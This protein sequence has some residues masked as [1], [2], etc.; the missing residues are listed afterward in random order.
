MRWLFIATPLL[1]FSLMVGAADNVVNFYTWADYVPA[2]IIKQFEKETG[3]TVNVSEFSNNDVMYTKIKTNPRAGYDVVLLSSDYLQ[4]MAKEGML[5]Q[6]NPRHI[7]N[8]VHIDTKEFN[9]PTD[10]LNHL[11]VPFFW[12]TTGILVNDKYWDPATIQ[13]WSDLW[14][15]RFKDQVLLFDDSI[16]TFAVG[17]KALHYSLNSTSATEIHAAYEKLRKLMPNVRLFNTDAVINI[18]ID[19]DATIGMVWNGD[20]ALAHKENPHLQF[21]YPKDG[22]TIWVDYFAV[23]SQAQHLRNAERL[24]NFF[25][26][27]DIAAKIAGEH[28]YSTANSGALALLPDSYRSNPVIH[29]S[30][31]VISRGEMQQYLGKASIIYQKYWQLLKLGAGT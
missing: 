26:R 30:H 21:V 5:Q 9:A 2:A 4:R 16:E 29:P 18:Y 14:Q 11:S 3:I 23:P 15:P 6:I 27:P 7:T 17:L 20:A 1:L 31:K 19:E 13:R 28:Y 22:F 12:G 10:P 24:I 8:L 25:S